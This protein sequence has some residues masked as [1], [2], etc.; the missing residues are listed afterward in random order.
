LKKLDEILKFFKVAPILELQGQEVQGKEVPNQGEE[1]GMKISSD[2]ATQPLAE[3]GRSNI[4]SATAAHASALGKG[5]AQLSDAGEQVMALIAQALQL[6][7]PRQEQVQALR[8]AVEAGNYAPN[9]QDV[10]A[11]I[12]NHLALQQATAAPDRGTGVAGGGPFALPAEYVAQTCLALLCEL[13]KSLK[14]DQTNWL[15]L[16]AAAT[17]QHHGSDGTNRLVRFSEIEESPHCA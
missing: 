8:Q 11:S 17:V 5:Q 2:H 1:A 7:E 6:P 9:P 3:S 15:A 16:D 12:L 4:R 13:E 10:A 14:A